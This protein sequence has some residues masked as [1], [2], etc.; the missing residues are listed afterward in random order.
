MAWRKL[1]KPRD[2]T[3]DTM[4]RIEGAIQALQELLPKDSP[5][6]GNGTIVDKAPPSEPQAS[7]PLSSK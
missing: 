7:Q 6:R 2:L 1:Q 5:D 3:H 4:L